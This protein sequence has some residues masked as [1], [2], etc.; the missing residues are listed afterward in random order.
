MLNLKT[1]PVP[2]REEATGAFR[3]GETC[4]L[5]EIVI[6]AFEGGATPKTIV[7]RYPTLRLAD[8]YAVI[9][10]PLRH[11]G[12]IQ[13]Y[14]RRRERR[15][16]VVRQRIDDAQGDL[17]EIRRRLLARRTFGCSDGG[18]CPPYEGD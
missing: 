7:R 2:V 15:A 4:V 11:S 6:R 12:E 1:D 5:L 14:L 9:A 17:G 13:E 8:V 18:R 16:A 10:Y 3:V